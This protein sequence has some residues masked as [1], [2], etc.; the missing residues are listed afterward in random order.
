MNGSIVDY[1]NSVGQKSDYASR[2]QL[3]ASKGISGY[4]G[5]A[6][7]NTQLLN[8]LRG[9]APAP[10]PQQQQQ[11]QQQSQPQPVSQPAQQQS[12]GDQALIDAMTQKGHTPETAKAAIAGRGY[13][14]LAREYLNT[15]SATVA[16]PG[17]GS[18]G[19]L[20]TPTI[21]LPE[22]YNNLFAKSGISDIEGKLAEQ[23]RGYNEAVA[24]IKDNPYLSEATMSGRL[25]KIDEKFDADSAALRGEVATRKADIETQLNLQTKQF[26]I[27]SQQAQLA[28]NQFNALLESG[29]LNSAGGEDIAN[30]TRATGLSSAVIQ[31]AIQAKIQSGYNSTTQSFDDGVNEGFIIYTLD[32]AGN[33]VNQSKQVTGKSSKAATQ[34][35]YSTDPGVSAFVSQFIKQQEIQQGWNTTGTSTSTPTKSSG[36]K[37]STSYKS[38]N[39]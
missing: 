26:D 23:T 28:L 32:P 4:T 13:D 33:I 39:A 37:V 14:N 38:Y 7:Q 10:Q 31:S 20:N 35:S 21:N 29:A 15:G 9:S 5:S 24:K 22:L 3:A 36:Q 27:N 25:R 6:Q 19:F 17:T 16:M 34:G 12:S 11:P 30:I 18:T 8:M 2:A 1:L